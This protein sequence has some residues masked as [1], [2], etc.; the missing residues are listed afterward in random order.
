[1][2]RYEVT[3]ENGQLSLKRPDEEIPVGSMDDVIDI[4]GDPIYAIQYTEEQQRVGWL[5]TDDDGQITFDIRETLPR[6]AFGQEFAE[7]VANTPLDKT[8][9]D[10]FP[11]RTSL[12]VD[13]VTHI[14]DSKGYI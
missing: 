11:A 12:F 4:V 1:M 9:E 3:V 10:G 13:L 5:E 8:D 2:E 14:W 7:N 6:L